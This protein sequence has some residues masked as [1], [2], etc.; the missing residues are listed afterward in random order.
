MLPML[1]YH[2]SFAAKLCKRTICYS[3]RSTSFLTATESL[4]SIV[5]YSFK[6]RQFK[7]DLKNNN[8]P[9]NNF[10]Q[11]ILEIDS[12]HAR[13]GE[14][15]LPLPITHVFGIRKD[16]TG[17]DVDDTLDQNLILSGFDTTLYTSITVVSAFVTILEKDTLIQELKTSR[18][19]PTLPAKL[20][21]AKNVMQTKLS[22]K[23][24]YRSAVYF[25]NVT[26][27]LPLLFRR[28]HQGLS[29]KDE[30]F[31]QQVDNVNLPQEPPVLY[32]EETFA[33]LDLQDTPSS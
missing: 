26:Y 15:G 5:H 10:D 18:K 2:H 21:T 8:C 3:G 33:V 20:N 23:T 30:E 29:P 28:I 27:E 24:T 6:L 14:D 12:M 32:Q 19:K 9:P 22:Q 7:K 1:K 13:L 16:Q 4:N 17:V 25:H 11:I 31:L